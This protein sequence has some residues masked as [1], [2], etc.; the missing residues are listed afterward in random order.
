[1]SK[2][3]I[4]YLKQVQGGQVLKQG[5]VWIG[6]MKKTFKHI[7]TRGVDFKAGFGPNVPN[8]LPSFYLEG[9]C[10]GYMIDGDKITIVRNE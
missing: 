10:G 2:V 3:Y 8:K 9:E 7:E 6:D 4:F 5:T 1:M